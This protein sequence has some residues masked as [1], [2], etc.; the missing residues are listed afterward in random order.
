MLRSLTGKVLSVTETSVLL[1]V[2]GLGFEVLVTGRAGRLCREGEEASLVTQL[3]ISE[4]GPMLFGFESERERS[5]FLKLTTVKGVGGKMAMNILRAAGTDHLAAWILSADISAL[6]K[7]PGVGRKT[8]ER[9]CFEMRASLTGENAEVPLDGYSPRGRMADAVME[10]LRSLGFTQG[11]VGAV[12][13]KLKAEGILDDESVNEEGL[14]R[15]A[16]KELKRN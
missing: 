10:A 7:I 6:M 11:D 16:L 2:H 12:F 5:F 4:A 14:L 8:A 13:R 1:D 9:L 3:Q 15:T